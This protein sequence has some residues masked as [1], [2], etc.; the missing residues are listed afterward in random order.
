MFRNKSPLRF[1]PNSTGLFS[2]S[3]LLVK[4]LRLFKITV[5][6]FIGEN[7]STA[8]VLSDLE[9]DVEFGDSS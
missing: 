7:A 4:G 8:K 3:M 6:E 5:F 2:S 9:G 1:H